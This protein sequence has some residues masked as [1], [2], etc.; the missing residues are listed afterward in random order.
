MKFDSLSKFI[1]YFK[2]EQ[3]CREH[4]EKVVWNGQ[5][6]CPY[7][8]SSKV[9]AFKDKKTYKCATKDCNKRFN[10][11]KGSIFESSNI[12]LQNWFIAI[13][14]LTMNKKGISSYQLARDLD[15]TQKTAWFLLHRIRKALRK[16]P[17][18]FTNIV[19]V[20]ETY[21]G[22]KNKNRH[23]NKRKKH[24]QGRSVTD[25]IPVFGI[26][27]RGGDVYTSKVKDV[28]SKSL[29]KIIFQYVKKGAHIMSDEWFA[30]RGL[31]FRYDHSVVEHG[32]Y[33]YV[34]GDCYTNSLEG[35][36]SLAKR[37]ILGI[38]HFISR[39]HT[40]S[41]FGEFDFRYNNRKTVNREDMF[42]SILFNG[43]NKRLSYK[44]LIF[45]VI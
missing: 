1:I 2:D 19:E 32:R 38:Y 4:L 15:I 11:L 9:Y 17:E 13:Y 20:D 41:Y 43:K 44:D 16:A 23:Y 34:K 45:S 29:K 35:Y 22:G 36:W 37:S 21:V 18:G 24:I 8:G 28:T 12:G 42:N 7:C 39:K 25:K 31:N 5:P 14:L 26:L 3:T 30:Y 40:D 6:T 10:V 27:E 33:Q